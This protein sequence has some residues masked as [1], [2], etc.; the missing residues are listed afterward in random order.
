MRLLRLKL[1]DFLI[2]KEVDLDLSKVK[3]VSIVGQH[4]E[5]N[6]RSN[7]SGKTAFVESIRYALFDESRGKSK[8]GIIREGAK[9]S[10]VELDFEINGSV[11]SVIRS[12][13]LDGT[14]AAKLTIDGK[15][16]GDKVKVVNDEL[17]RLIGVDAA[18]FDLIYFFKQNDQFGFAEASAGERKEILAK[19]FRMDQLARCHKMAS[20][21]HRTSRDSANRLQGGYDAAKSR[22]QSLPTY[23]EVADR[24]SALQSH[25][26]VLTVKLR[27][28]LKL[29]EDLDKSMAEFAAESKQWRD[30]LEKSL[31]KI[32]TVRHAVTTVTDN[33]NRKLGEK[34]NYQLKVTVGTSELNK[35][36][37]KVLPPDVD[38]K[39]LQSELSVLLTGI[40]SLGS[41][42]QTNQKIVA[43]STSAT[44]F[45]MMVGKECSQC[46]Q[47]VDESHV[48]HIVDGAMSDAREAAARI[49]SMK[50]ATKQHEDDVKSKR[51]AIVMQEEKDATIRKIDSLSKEVKSAQAFLDSLDKD[52]AALDE[53]LAK[54]TAEYDE[55]LK[56]TDESKRKETQDTVNA[57]MDEFKT[58]K[59]AFNDSI[60]SLRVNIKSD[61]TSFVLAE[62]DRLSREAAEKNLEETGTKY[63]SAR[64]DERV[65]DI[66]TGVFGKN[67]IQALVIENAIGAIEA[68]ANDILQQMHTRFTIALK[69]QKQ[70]KSG[71]DRESLDIAVYDNGQ[72]R[73]FEQY[74]G[75]EKTLVNLAIRLALSRV[76][77]SLHGVTV[78][79][80]FLDEILGSLDAVNREEVVKV[81]G[82]LSRSFEFVAVISHTQEILSLVD[83]G[84]VIRRHTDHST[85]SLTHA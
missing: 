41:M 71:E 36:N 10:L 11:V 25:L 76:I 7:G 61:E 60:E 42:I 40:G 67:G 68:F 56:A 83:A 31:S 15:S 50:L 72:E 24:K 45:Q 77:S 4:D 26:T 21:N 16:S 22:L 82:F 18:L 74:S 48:Q 85:A 43:D 34:K 53:Q 62:Q 78:K 14:S 3:L 12:R 75:G 79:S 84:I 17:A 81:I 8:S 52:I 38:V 63:E 35:L 9:R 46:R 19:L 66:L 33:R 23:Q 54:A 27:N 70:L 5:D 28:E 58:L 30:N 29:A 55:V 69:T 20:E 47:I 65:Y 13:D 2:F 44:R 57:R 64:K 80:L 51:D 1:R 39:A 59:S 73:P 6:R 37:Q 32:S 49:E